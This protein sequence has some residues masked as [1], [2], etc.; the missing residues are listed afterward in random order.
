MPQKLFICETCTTADGQTPG[1]DLA[2]SV[3]QALEV[4]TEVV[5][6]ECL[7]ICDEPVS[8][9]LRAPGK[10]AYLFS[11]V[12]AGDAVDIAALARLYAEAPDGVIEDARPAGRLRFCLKGRVPA[13]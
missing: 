11:G 8:L 7:N 6:V 4:E 5:L 1:A 3:S 2:R 10:M 12:E 13:V 9:A